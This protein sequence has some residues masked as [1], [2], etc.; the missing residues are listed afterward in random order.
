METI[1]PLLAQFEAETNPFIALVTSTLGFMFFIA[2]YVVMAVALMTIAKKTDTPNEWMAWV[3]I[4]NI[5]LMIQ[6]AGLE[7]WYIVLCFIPC[8]NLFAFIY[9]WWKVAEARDKPGPIAL[10]MLVPV[11]NLAVPLY[12][13]FSE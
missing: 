5:V 7:L 3:P 4:L 10:L 2:M 9:I 1:A 8:V 13:A 6:I 12:I 11:L